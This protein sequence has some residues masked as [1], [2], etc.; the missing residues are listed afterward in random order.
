MEKD[1]KPY[2]QRG[3]T[4]AV[5]CMLMVLEYYEI[6]PKADWI[7]EKKYF[8]AYKSKHMEGTPF[9]ALAWHFAKNGLDTEIMH[10]EKNIFDNSKRAL[11]DDV[12]E[13][14]MK[15]YF[16]FL[17]IAKEKG[18]KISNGCEISCDILKQKLDEGKL[19]VLAGLINNVLHA[20]L[21]CGYND[22]EFVVCDPLYRQKQTK[23]YNEIDSYM[24][25][26]LGKW[27]VVVGNK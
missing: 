24:N 16:C 5:A 4:C 2:K 13:N 27:C 1:V 15:E 12:F 7:Y 23:S 21:I 3:M 22:G 10:S 17:E 25:T 11:A 6:I 14:A 18:A 9:S 20:I 8:R 19:I 26:P